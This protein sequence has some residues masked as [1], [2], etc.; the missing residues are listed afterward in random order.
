[1][2]IKLANH[3][4]DIGA[5]KNLNLLSIEEKLFVFLLVFVVNDSY[6]KVTEEM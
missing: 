1:V 6:Y 4:Y 3:L 5:V 2:F